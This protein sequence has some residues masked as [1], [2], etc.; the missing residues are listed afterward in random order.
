MNTAAVLVGILVLAVA[1]YVVTTIRIYEA[2]RKRNVSVSFLFLRILI[3]D[4]VAQYKQITLQETGRVGP[5]FY[6]WLIS[7]NV[8]LVSAILV[9]LLK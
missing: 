7:I 9:L 6:H 1:W 5:L 2:L 4:Y 8:A 3:L